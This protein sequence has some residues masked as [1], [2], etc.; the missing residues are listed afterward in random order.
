MGGEH[1]FGKL[2][3]G[4]QL[5]KVLLTSPCG[6]AVAFSDLRPILPGHVVVA[7]ARE[8]RRLADLTGD[9][10]AT[11][12]ETACR[13]QALAARDGATAFNLAINDGEAA[14]QPALLPHVHLHVVPRREGDLAQNDA[15]YDLLGRWAPEGPETVPPPFHV[16]SDEER[17]PRTAAQMAAES[18]R[19]AAA[20]GVGTPLPTRPFRFSAAIAVDPSQLFFASPRSVAAVNLKPLCPGHVLV[21]PRRIVATL[22]LLQPAERADLWQAARDVAAL[23]GGCH[24]AA[25]CK[26]AVQDGAAAG[27]SVAHVHVH[28]LPQT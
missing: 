12:F 28:V 8:V 25:G 17:R 5:G 3:V 19:Y 27:Q 15:V 24:G 14:G 18:A 10:M 23:V 9:E 20:A 22:D 21:M 16:P 6:L 7:P 2:V 11:L 26:L 13:V 1:R 4:S